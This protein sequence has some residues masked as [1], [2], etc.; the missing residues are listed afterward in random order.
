[1]PTPLSRAR[2]PRRAPAEVLVEAQEV[3]R[4]SW[5]ERRP[6]Q[7]PPNARSASLRANA[8]RLLH[9]VRDAAEHL[10]HGR[11]AASGASAE[12]APLDTAG[13]DERI[14]PPDDFDVPEFIP[15]R[16]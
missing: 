6:A 16:R 8:E 5:H 3:V 12:P 4:P 9:D 14:A 11:A 13:R 2:R 1:M 10:T 15:G 7:R